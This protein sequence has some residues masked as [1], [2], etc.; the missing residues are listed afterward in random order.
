MP[1]TTNKQRRFMNVVKAIKSG[2]MSPEK[3]GDKAK[4]AAESMSSKSVDEFAWTEGELPEEA[5]KKKKNN[6]NLELWAEENVEN[7]IWSIIKEE[8][9]VPEWL[10]NIPIETRYEILSGFTLDEICNGNIDPVIEEAYKKIEVI[11]SKAL[12]NFPIG[13]FHR[14]PGEKGV[15]SGHGTFFTGERD[16]IKEQGNEPGQSILS[17]RDY[18]IKVPFEKEKELSDKHEETNLPSDDEKK[19]NPRHP[20]SI[21]ILRRTSKS[22]Q[23]EIKEEIQKSLR[24]YG[25]K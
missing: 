24:K 10:V 11:K 18:I 1:S 15:T 17:M 8:T 23:E 3:A 14:M 19:D 25:I 9:M 21:D 6:L 4:K 7:D 20:R 12:K 16:Y 22:R 13:K 5:P 2:K